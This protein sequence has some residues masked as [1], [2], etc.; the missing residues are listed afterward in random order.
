MQKFL[1]KSSSKKFFSTLAMLS[2]IMPGVLLQMPYQQDAK[3][4]GVAAGTV[5]GNQA[6]ASYKDQNNNT[7]NSTSNLVNTIVAEV[8]GVML[9]PDGTIAAPGQSQTAT[10]GTIVYYPYTLTNTGNTADNYVITT[11]TGTSNTFTP[12]NRKV[13]YDTN[14]NGIVDVGDSQILDGGQTISIPA[15]GNIKLIV[16]YQV[17]VAAAS[18]QVAYVNIIANS[19]KDTTTFGNID[20][21]G[22]DSTG[23]ALATDL[24]YNRTTV[25]NDAVVSITKSVVGNV[26]A[27]DPSTSTPSVINNELTYTL[28]A[29][30]TGSNNANNIYIVDAIPTNTTFKVGSVTAP[31]GVLIEYSNSLTGSVFTATPSGTYDTAIKRIRYT[32][33]TA[34]GGQLPPNNSR[35]F[36]FT[37]RVN[38]NAPATN[39]LNAADF[40]YTPIGS[41]TPVNDD[42]SDGTADYYS[43]ASPQRDTNEVAVAINKKSAAQISFN[44]TPISGSTVAATQDPAYPTATSDTTTVPSAAA[45][46]YLYFKNVVTNNGNATDLFDIS[47]DAAQSKLPAGAVVRFYIDS[48][49]APT[50]N[51]LT[52]PYGYSPLLNTGGGAD[53]DTGNVLT[54]GTYNIITEVFIPAGTA[55]T[56]TTSTADA[57]AAQPTIAVTTGTGTLFTAG[58]KVTI[59]GTVYTV[60]SST[61][62]S[63]TFT[64]N[65]AALVANGTS[66]SKNTIAV[67]KATSSNGGTPINNS[68]AGLTTTDTTANILTAITA[69]S[70]DL[71]N[72]YTN[73]LVNETN[74]SLTQSSLGATI[75]Y[76]LNIRNT[77]GSPDTYNLTAPSGFPAGSTI[78]FYPL[79]PAS[80]TTV[81]DA[82]ITAG[83]TSITLATGGGA[84]YTA[85]DTI[86][87]AGQ[88]FTVGSVAGD[89]ITFSTGQS[90]SA[91]SLPVTGDAVVERSNAPI[92]NTN[93]IPS[94]GAQQVIAVVSTT[95]TTPGTYNTATFTATS[96]NNA[97]VSNSIVDTLVIPNFRNFTLTQDRTGSISP[98]GTLTYPHT[99]TN[100]G[101]VTENFYIRV[102]AYATGLNYILTDTAGTVIGTLNNNGTAGDTTDDYYEYTTGTALN[103]SDTFNF[104][105]KVNAPTNVA[106]NTI[107]SINITARET[108]SNQTLTNTDVTSVVEGF[109]QL[110]KSATIWTYGTNGLPATAT[111]PATAGT[112][113]QL[114]PADGKIKPGEVIEY[115]IVYTN[116]GSVNATEVKIK[117]LIPANTTYVPG[118]LVIGTTYMTDTVDADTADGSQ[119]LGTNFFVG[120]SATG[121]VGGTVAQ[122]GSGT[123]KFRVRVN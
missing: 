106:I 21:D 85:G 80:T 90:L 41:G 46:T 117:D 115:T 75:S 1:K 40:Q 19:V 32:M 15:D 13:Y 109:I 70:V 60:A 50:S 72:I 52:S 7:Y 24:N 34:N 79:I 88:T 96:N 110:V 28:D 57:A 97:T 120:T 64:T 54:A 33:N 105:V 47:L 5:I 84:Q 82:S 123:D 11:I 29:S 59:A 68:V 114:T 62:T 91:N 44:A 86:I 119:A 14:G 16:E 37:V 8:Y 94:G 112:S 10:P 74:V 83:D 36:G 42:P 18:T 27:I 104:Q 65:L 81:N 100:T 102:P 63:V 122:G 30:N 35:S 93:L 23:T 25:V 9:T 17:P 121:T 43:A 12:A 48:I 2:L 45:G 103:P 26:T 77:G 108:T 67:V 61:S 69:P 49:A 22:F 58:D 73:S 31:A 55:T 111:A 6:T 53:P 56:V 116:T 101:N 76:P 51:P 66:I 95:T 38:D 78:T 20:G 3:A 118:S 39:I 92:T 107:S 99:V 87:I 71:S 98:G 4:A 89:T 113:T